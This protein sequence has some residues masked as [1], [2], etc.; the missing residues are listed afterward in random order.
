M[1]L[2]VAFSV[3]RGNPRSGGQGVYTHYL[4]KALRD[5]GHEV[6]VFSGQPYPELAEDIALVKLP[7][8]DMYRAA[9]PFRWPKLR[10]MESAADIAEVLIRLFGGFPEPRTFSAR[11]KKEI[12]AQLDPF[13]VLHDNQSIGNG[14]AAVAKTGLPIVASV[15]HPIDVDRKIDLL[16]SPS[17][18]D[19]FSKYRW[20]GFAGMQS[21]VARQLERIITVSEHAKFDITKYMGVRQSNIAVIHPGV[22]TKVFYPGDEALKK[23]GQII[24]VTSAD[25]HMKGL[26]VLVEAMGFVV[27]ENP[28]AKLVVIGRLSPDGKSHKILEQRDLL[29][30]CISFVHGI[31]DIEL[32]NLYRESEVAAIPSLYEGFSLPAIQALASGLP[33]AAT[34][35]GALPEVLGENGQC[36]LLVEPGDP[37]ALAD[38]ILILLENRELRSKLSATGSRRVADNFTWL[39][40]AEKVVA[41]YRYAID[42][43][44]YRKSQVHADR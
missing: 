38:A 17:L 27:K 8:L 30:D 4:T 44:N 35:G 36:A 10:E 40:T 12:K 26:A 3:Y 29:N 22:D 13:D 9:D 15:H 34:T 23:R 33:V 19:K 18:K 21:S 31:S 7:S 43:F 42:K 37:M 25:T 5:L 20:Y 28:G 24:A 32:A 6:T 2:K 14:I 11:L 16:L 41:E 1:G 39:K